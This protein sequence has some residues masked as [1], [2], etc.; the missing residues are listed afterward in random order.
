MNIGIRIENFS[1]WTKDSSEPR[2]VLPYTTIREVAQ[3]AEEGG[4]DSIWL[5]DHLL[6]RFQPEI[7]DRYRYT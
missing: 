6:Y 4:F 3:M 1:P 7:A 2:V 5:S